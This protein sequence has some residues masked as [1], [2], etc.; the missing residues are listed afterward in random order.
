MTETDKNAF[1]PWKA[2]QYESHSH[3]RNYIVTRSMIA[4]PGIVRFHRSSRG[5]P[6]WYTKAGADKKAAALNAVEETSDEQ[7]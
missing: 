4:T 1:G 2:T 3:G 5:G 7:A 6:V